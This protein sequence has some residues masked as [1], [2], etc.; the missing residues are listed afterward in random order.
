MNNTPLLLDIMANFAKEMVKRPTVKSWGV[1]TRT[2]RELGMSGGITLTVR[3]DGLAVATIMGLPVY[4]DS[5]SLDAGCVALTHEE[6]FHRDA[7]SI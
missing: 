5:V 4:V 1:D 6:V 3:D 2:F 7:K